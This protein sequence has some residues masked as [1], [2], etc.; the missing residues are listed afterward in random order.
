MKSPVCVNNNLL[1]NDNEKIK[2]LIKYHCIWNEERREVKE[3]DRRS[4]EEEVTEENLVKMVKKVKKA[5]N[6]TQNN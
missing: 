3:E 4:E 5:L 2:R 1:N 6:R